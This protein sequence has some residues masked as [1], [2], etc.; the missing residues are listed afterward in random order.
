MSN[1]ISRRNLIKMGATAGCVTSV[2]VMFQ[3]CSSLTAANTVSMASVASTGSANLPTQTA[4]ATASFSTDLNF[5]RTAGFYLAGDGGGALYRRVNAQPTHPLKAQSADGAWW[6]LVSE[7]GVIN[8]KQCGAIGDNSHDD[9]QSIQ[10]AI[11]GAPAGSVIFVPPGTYKVTGG[12]NIFHIT[13]PLRILGAGQQS[14]IRSVGNGHLFVF[15]GS[16]IQCG[17]FGISIGDISIATEVGGDPLRIIQ[18]HRNQHGPLWIPSAN[19]RAAISL[20]GS[21]YNTFMNPTIYGNIRVSY[22]GNYAAPVYGILIGDSPEDDI[23]YSGHN[24]IVTPE[25]TGLTDSPGEGIGIYILNGS[26]N[27]IV[28]GCSA[29]N[30]VGLKIAPSSRGAQAMNS[31]M[32]LI[33]EGNSVCNISCSGWGNMFVNCQAGNETDN[34]SI[35]GYALSGNT[36]SVRGGRCG[37]VVIQAGSVGNL[38]GDGVHLLGGV[39]DSGTSTVIE[40]VWDGVANTFKRQWT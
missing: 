24:T 9:T 6:E 10:N 19:S 28:G 30:K 29:A 31:A 32:N 38:I 13:K 17:L 8:I 18:C 16:G 25:I 3:N 15:D 4:I 27:T 20:I 1:S 26:H 2:A 7:N 22:P 33:C 21:M 11:A 34:P 14:L 5:I 23:H 36:H 37:R 35:S 39:S 12:G 40:N